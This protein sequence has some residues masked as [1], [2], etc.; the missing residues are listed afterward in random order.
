MSEAD[1]SGQRLRSPAF[2]WFFTGWS[3]TNAGSALSP[4]ALAFGVL[5]AT[6][7]A[8][9]LSAVLTASMVPM[10]ATMILAGGVA[11]RYRRDTVL[12]LTS[13]GSGISQTG[14]AVVLLSH[15][16]PVLLLPL[17]AFNG[18][19]QALTTPTMRGMVPLLASG[20]RS[21]ILSFVIAVVLFLAGK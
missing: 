4:V 6:G 21:V 17:A 1:A 11:D 2:R 20:R 18:V 13:L 5:E 15:R 3:I 8:A 14:V 10:I 9:W 19:F 7:S 16:S 12:R